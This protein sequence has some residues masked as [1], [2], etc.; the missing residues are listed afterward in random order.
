MALVSATIASE[1]LSAT[2]A[3]VSATIGSGLLSA[4][5][6]L[7]SA[8]I[9]WELLSARAIAHDFVAALELRKRK[10]GGRQSPFLC[11]VRMK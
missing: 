8:T 1:L 11:I 4:P 10:C 3:L 2:M 5:I 9:A 7:V 6:D